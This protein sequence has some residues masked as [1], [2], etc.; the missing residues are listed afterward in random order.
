MGVLLLVMMGCSMLDQLNRQAAQPKEMP[1][2]VAQI[3]QQSGREWR[4]DPEYNQWYSVGNP[5]PLFAHSLQGKGKGK[6]QSVEAQ[7]ASCPEDPN[8]DPDGDGYLEYE[9]WQAV[10][11]P[12]PYSDDWNR[13]E[14]KTV[15]Y[16]D[17]YHTFNM[18]YASCRDDLQQTLG[19]PKTQ[20]HMQNIG[21]WYWVQTSG[22]NTNPHW[23]EVIL[24]NGKDSSGWAFIVELEHTNGTYYEWISNGVCN[25]S[26]SSMTVTEVAKLPDVYLF[27]T[28]YSRSAIRLEI[29]CPTNSGIVAVGS[30]DPPGWNNEFLYDPATLSKGFNVWAE[31]EDNKC[32]SGNDLAWKNDNYSGARNTYFQNMRVVE[33]EGT[34]VNITSSSS[35]HIQ[36]DLYVGDDTGCSWSAPSKSWPSSSQLKISW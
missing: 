3:M 15:V 31:W 19:W 22:Q 18:S 7:V 21:G 4:Y 24:T 17:S 35:H 28:N 12:F 36:Y 29:T 23:W 30:L 26:G 5:H 16:A 11:F 1:D 20:L 14:V 27:P 25:P 13:I 8:P 9:V 6:G 2:I 10:S 33:R 32:P 34:S